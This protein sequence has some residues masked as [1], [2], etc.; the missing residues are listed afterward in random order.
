MS[1]KNRL[2]FRTNFRFHN[3]IDTDYFGF[4][5]P[6]LGTYFW[7]ESASF[8]FDDVHSFSPTFVMDVK[9][10]DSRFVRAQDTQTRQQFHVS[11]LGLP[12]Y[13]ESAIKP[14]FQRFPAITTNGYT[15]LAPR[16]WLYKGTETR[17]AAVTFDKIHGKHDFKFGFEVRQYPQNQ[18]S[19]SA[20]TA[21]NL[22]FTEAYT[23][24][25]LDNSPT[26]PRGQALAS[27]L[28]GIASGGS[29]TIP[30]ATD[31]AMESK[32]WA[33]YFQNDWKVTRNLR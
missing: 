13:V 11:S 8:A 12:S 27:M 6:S 1:D 9:V 4:D 20:S 7:N 10:N 29:L 21:L 28:F 24:G 17:A 5:N 16:T 26:A 3:I 23:R 19:G 30:A 14:Q 32:V 33:G 15:S 18:T 31:Y 22:S 25:P 2:M